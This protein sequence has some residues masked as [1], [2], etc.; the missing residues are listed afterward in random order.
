M[1]NIGLALSGGG[2]RASV[3]NLGVLLY[4]ADAGKNTDVRSIASVSGGSVTNG[5]VAQLGNYDRG[6]AAEFRA[7]TMPLT[8][9]LA[10]KGTLWAW[11][12]TW[13]YLAG[14]ILSVLAIVAIA[15]VPWSSLPVRLLVSLIVLA[16][17]GK[18]GFEKRGAVCGCAFA[19]TLFS[20]N[21]KAIRLSETGSV[22]IDHVFCATELHAGEHLYFSGNFICSY[23]F[24]WGTPANL[25]L[26]VAVQASAA[27]PGAFPPRILAASPHHFRDGK[28]SARCMFL[29]DGGA[30]DNMADQWPM[31]IRTRK[32]RWPGHAR[33]LVEL[34]EVV[35]VNAS[36]NMRWGPINRLLIPIINEVLSMKRVID[37]L[38][39]NTTTVRR[40]F[41]MSEFDSAE[42]SGGT[43]RGA[44]VMLEQS[45]F[46]VASVFLHDEERWPT[47]AAR[48]KVAI[49]SLG[50]TENAWNKIVRQNCAVPTT[51]RSLGNEVVARLLYQA[52]VTAM[53]N[54]HVILGYP[55]LPMPQLADFEALVTEA[56]QAPGA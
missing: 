21:G 20:P 15:F 13:L 45:P 41:L 5:Y 18:M 27:F 24:G 10:S 33:D 7:A 11:W 35:V 32:D 3:F 55:L 8:A 34:D 12:G 26:H 53:C 44:L 39:D 40:R 51:F 22:A 14:M 56:S 46:R 42:K 23:R 30:Y 4:L 1:P 43:P 16:I 2:N 52:Y 54:L 49:A 48:A 17:V 37:V 47:R 9:R 29:Q 38:Y 6:T 36:T 28:N 25:P 19:S 31:G 50:E